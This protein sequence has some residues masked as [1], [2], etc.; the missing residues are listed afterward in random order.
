M[1]ILD[2]IIAAKRKEFNALRRVYFPANSILELLRINDES[3]DFVVIETL[4]SDWY[5]EYAEYRSQ[6]KLQIARGVDFKDTLLQVS[7]VRVNEDV[8]WVEKSD[9]ISPQGSN[10]IW[11]LFCGRGF[12]RNSFRSPF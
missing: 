3:N 11:Q 4:L 2:K 5:L 6:F 12:S 8:Y 1:A 10:P 7:N 9:V